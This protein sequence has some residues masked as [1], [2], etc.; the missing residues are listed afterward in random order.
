MG[1]AL[2]TGCGQDTFHLVSV[3]IAELNLALATG[4]WPLE[5][6]QK[7]KKRGGSSQS[8]RLQLPSL[9]MKCRENTGDLYRAW[10]QGKCELSFPVLGKLSVTVLVLIDIPK[11]STLA[12]AEESLG[13]RPPTSHHRDSK[14]QWSTRAGK[15]EQSS[16]FIPETTFPIPTIP[17]PS[18]T[19]HHHPS[20]R[21][22]EGEPK[23]VSQPLG[24][25]LTAT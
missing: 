25:L 11:S 3:K 12:W 19:R 9:D 5:A 15:G 14:T 23:P 16:L 10:E 6:L 22:P 8:A 21:R 24:P 4:P 1:P 18:R 2:I 17:A 13:G 7:E 20:L